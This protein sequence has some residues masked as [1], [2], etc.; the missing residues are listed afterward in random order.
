MERSR[1]IALMLLF[2]RSVAFFL[3]ILI[4][5][6]VLAPAGLLVQSLLDYQPVTGPE[7]W[8][9]LLWNFSIPVWIYFI[10]CD[11]SRTG[12]TLGKRILGLRV[13][14]VEGDMPLGFWLAFGRNAVKLLPWELVHFSAF[15]ISHDLSRLS[16][17]QTFGLTL[18]NALIVI[19][20]VTAAMSR[21]HRSVHDYA[22]GT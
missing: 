11:M 7:I 21:G 15:A 9:A 17:G 14:R 16:A 6:A 12:A 1:G 2:R 20:L 19:Y 18:A 8:T 22:A 4:L 5:F 13:R 10:L 3:D